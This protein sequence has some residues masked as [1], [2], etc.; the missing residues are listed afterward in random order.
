MFRA[1]HPNGCNETLR[2][3]TMLSLRIFL[4][5]R[6]IRELANRQQSSF[7]VFSRSLSEISDRDE[8]VL[9]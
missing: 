1:C 6:R 7:Q 9:V 8:G 2:T 5:N 3:A 4:F